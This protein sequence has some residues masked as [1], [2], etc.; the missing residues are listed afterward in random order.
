MSYNSNRLSVRRIIL[1]ILI[2]L[3]VIIIKAGYLVHENWYWVL[4][5]T[6]PMLLIAIRDTRQKKHAIIRNYPPRRHSP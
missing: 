5:I 3:N 6:G 4:C 2:L 1:S